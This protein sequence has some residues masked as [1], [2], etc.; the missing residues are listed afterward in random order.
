MDQYSPI[1]DITPLDLVAA[2]TNPSIST[3]SLTTSTGSPTTPMPNTDT[4]ITLSWMT[5][6]RYIMIILI[7]AFLGFN[8]F[9]TLGEITDKLKQL[10]APLLS[11]LGY[12][13]GQTIKQTTQVSATGAKA[14]IDIA[15]GTIDDAV[16]LL[17]KGVGVKDVSFKHIDDTTT[18]IDDTTT[19]IDD[20]TTHIDNR[21]TNQDVFNQSVKHKQRMT[22]S[23]D[24]AGS[25]TQ[26]TTIPKSGFCY[27]GEDRGFR[28]CIKVENADECMSGDIFPSREICVNPNLRD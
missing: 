19:H 20:T 18:H 15:A 13:I 21:T 26:R 14:G 24:E 11:T 4:Y 27:I 3:G 25:T 1:T 2:N 9:G 22:P 7:L 6:F 5:I 12:D 10:L 17:E 23:P 28:S 16:T 8:L